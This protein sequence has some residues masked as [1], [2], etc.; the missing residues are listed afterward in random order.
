MERVYVYGGRINQGGP[1]GIS[2]FGAPQQVTLTRRVYVSNE[3]RDELPTLYP[4]VIQRNFFEDDD[5]PSLFP[6]METSM[7][8]GHR[9]YGS[10]SPSSPP[11]KVDSHMRT[12]GY[13]GNDSPG[14]FHPMVTQPYYGHESSA[15]P[16]RQGPARGNPINL[17]VDIHMM[18]Q[19][20]YPPPGVPLYG[21]P[22]P[23]GG[24]PYGGPQLAPPPP[25]PVRPQQPPT[26]N[27]VRPQQPPTANYQI[28]G[29]KYNPQIQGGVRSKGGDVVMG[30]KMR[31]RNKFGI[32]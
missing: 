21:S 15:Y 29:G 16:A 8:T 31:D 19:E 28:G 3:S 5:Y 9:F 18:P 4:F 2:G 17:D 1:Q 32:D 6:T 14:A 13:Y 25:P 11:S 12:S 23:Y 26:A 24:P 30:P 10:D 20:E 27:S 22:A 7:I